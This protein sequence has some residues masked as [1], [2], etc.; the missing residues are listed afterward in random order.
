[1]SLISKKWLLAVGYQDALTANNNQ[2]LWGE[3]ENYPSKD[4]LEAHDP[5]VKLKRGSDVMMR[6]ERN[7]R[8]TNHN[9]SVG[10]LPIY[11]FT[12]DQIQV[13]DVYEKLDGTVGLALTA[14]ATAGYH[15]NVKSSVK[16]IVGIK[17]ANRDV[18][19]DQLTRDDVQTIAYTYKF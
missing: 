1:M 19:P 12:K 13:N 10:A 16:L 11:R 17:I 6:V 18:N 14:L 3:W 2:F 9:F 8:F 4:Y 7:W 15:F 5:S